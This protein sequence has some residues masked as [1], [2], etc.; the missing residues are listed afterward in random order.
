MRELLDHSM[1]K[2]K[3]SVMMID[4]YDMDRRYTRTGYNYVAQGLVY[5]KHLVR[6]HIIT[7][8]YKA[9]M[10]TIRMLMYIKLVVVAEYVRR[11]LPRT[12]LSMDGQ[13]FCS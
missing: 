11:R 12:I 8:Q 7:S 3:D 13:L 10:D 5:M 1:S 2:M 4:G 9:Y 6:K